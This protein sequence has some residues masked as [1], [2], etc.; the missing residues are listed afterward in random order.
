M[1]E[2]DRLFNEMLV[3]ELRK[4]REELQVTHG[5]VSRD[6]YKEM[7]TSRKLHLVGILQGVSVAVDVIEKRIK[8]WESARRGRC[9][10]GLRGD[11]AWP[12]RRVGGCVVTSP[13]YWSQRD[14]GND[15]QIGRESVPL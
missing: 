4:I 14:Y 6:F 1:N 12:S 10:A 9:I 7:D 3:S 5:D 13:P 15:G 11:V 8:F 2:L